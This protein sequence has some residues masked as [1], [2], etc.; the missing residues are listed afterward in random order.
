MDQALVIGRVFTCWHALKALS[1]H[2]A[3]TQGSLSLDNDDG[4]DDENG[5]TRDL[6]K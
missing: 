4:E 2:F 6:W 3:L 5:A 1:I